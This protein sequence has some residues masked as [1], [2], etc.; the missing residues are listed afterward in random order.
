MIGVILI[1][2]LIIIASAVMEAVRRHR[3]MQQQTLL[4]ALAA[5]VDRGIPLVQA[6][7]AYA[8]EIRGRYGLRIAGFSHLLKQGIAVPRALSIER[9]VFPDAVLPLLLAGFSAGTPGK[10]IRRSLNVLK[11]QSPAEGIAGR[12]AYLA[13]FVLMTAA[14]LTFLC[15]RIAPQYE[16]IFVEFE[17]TL[18]PA[19]LGFLGIFR[20]SLLGVLAFWLFVFLLLFVIYC[21]LRILGVVAWE[22]PGIRRLTRRPHAAAILDGLALAVESQQPL[23]ACVQTLAQQH[24]HWYVRAQLNWIA[25]DLDVGMACWDSLYNRGLIGGA[26]RALLEAAHRAGNLAWAL[27]E[28]AENQRRRWAYQLHYAAH[29]LY[30]ALVLMMGALVLWVMVAFFSPLV[31]LIKGLA[32]GN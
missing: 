26:D 28:V 22:P 4:C 31:Y 17:M 5:T 16:K 23:T 29:L 7:D 15:I 32:G 27:G 13:L 18:P 30:P 12:L 2:G 1:I 24:P 20:Q 19:T 10:A 11:T 9:K 25:V 8:H 3:R 14:V 6:L 21:V